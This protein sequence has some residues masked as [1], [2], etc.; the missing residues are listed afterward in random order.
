MLTKT[1]LSV[2]L[3]D[4][5]NKGRIGSSCVSLGG[6]GEE[7][8]EVLGIEGGVWGGCVWGEHPTV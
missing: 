4:T 6:S 1:G 8:S 2:C 5:T 3:I 7:S